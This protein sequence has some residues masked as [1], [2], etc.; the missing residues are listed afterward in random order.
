MRVD[1][2][3]FEDVIKVLD[4]HRGREFCRAGLAGR[5][6]GSD[7]RGD[8]DVFQEAIADAKFVD[9]PNAE[10]KRLPIVKKF[11]C[12]FSTS[13]LSQTRVSNS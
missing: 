3:N 2:D 7:G 1:R 10:A 11:T 9:N 8:V 12:R 6:A 13:R 5:Y 4:A